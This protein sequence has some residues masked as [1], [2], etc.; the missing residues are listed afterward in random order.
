M[1]PNKQEVLSFHASRQLH[2]SHDQLT[3]Q[4]TSLAITLSVASYSPLTFTTISFSALVNHILHSLSLKMAGPKKVP[5]Y[6]VS[7]ELRKDLERAEKVYGM[8]Y[9]TFGSYM[10]SQDLRKDVSNAKS[11]GSSADDYGKLIETAKQQDDKQWRARLELQRKNNTEERRQKKLKHRLAG[12]ES[13]EDTQ[14]GASNSDG[15]DMDMEFDNTSR[16]GSNFS[17]LNSTDEDIQSPRSNELNDYPI[18][19][20]YTSI[21]P[22]GHNM[23]NLMKGKGT[24]VRQAI[25]ALSSL[26][27][28]INRCETEKQRA[29][30]VKYFDE[31][32]D[33]VHKAEFLKGVNKY[34]LYKIHMLDN[35]LK[36]IF[37]SNVNFPWDLRADAIQLW[38]R[39]CAQDFSVD[40][41]RGIT[42]SKTK[43]GEGRISD[44]IDKAWANKY[45]AKYYGQG[46]LV[47][48]QWWPTQL[49]TV[50]DGAH[51]SAMGGIYG[52]K[53]KGAYSIVLSGGN[54]YGDVDEGEQI[55]Y[56]GTD[57]KGDM[58]ATENTQRMIESCDNVHEPVRV[59]RS[60][61]LQKSNPYRPLRGF[62]YDGLYDVI[63]YKVVDQAKAVHKFKLIRQKGQKPIRYEDKPSRRPTK[64][65]I[66]EYDR[67]VVA[68]GYDLEST[69]SLS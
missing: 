67:Q 48:G 50:R 41:L 49:C 19:T 26:K 51:G 13:G 8:S 21:S 65:E 63:E 68:R 59:I 69:N 46:D 55:W 10:A 34:V 66:E 54:H 4:A 39:W 22:K 12:Q 16:R 33:H 64:W 1:L 61:N 28:C 29:Q 45:S 42:I 47:L 36:R 60:W 44:K 18:P 43:S 3:S 31:L 6:E 7:D 56:S 30:L 23:R 5:A 38:H 20:W 62:R 32:R 37:V 53:G 24:E 58:K 14:A 9:E 2:Q 35:G 17:L 40:L 15:M 52:E 57:G 27:E 25:T 11:L